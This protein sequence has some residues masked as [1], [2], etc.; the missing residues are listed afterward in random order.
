M[1]QIYGR[2]KCK[3]SR[4][5][6][7]FFKERNVPFSYVDLDQKAPGRRE[8][9]LFLDVLGEDAVVDAESKA[10]KKCGLAYMDYDATEEIGEHPE[11][12]R[13]PIVREGRKLSAGDAPEFW[14]ELAANS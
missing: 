10:F 3:V 2:R 7:R 5:A 13:T 11:L 8:V 14:A 6:E 12:L 4:K 1:I 9:E